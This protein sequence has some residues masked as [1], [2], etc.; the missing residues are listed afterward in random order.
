MQRATAGDGPSVEQ[1]LMRYLPRLRAFIRLRVDALLRQ[2][3]SCSDLVQS[4]CRDVLEH[5]GTFTYQ[6]EECFR[7]WLF[8]AALNKILEHRRALGSEKRDVRREQ[9]ITGELDFADL[10]LALQSPSRVAMMLA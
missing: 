6:G 1:L 7:A 8:K 2:R 10:R 5:A 3:E 9:A 4:V